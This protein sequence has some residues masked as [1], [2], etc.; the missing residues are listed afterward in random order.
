MDA[1]DA[2]INLAGS[3]QRIREIGHC[4]ASCRSKFV[5]NVTLIDTVGVKDS[6]GESEKIMRT[7]KET[8]PRHWRVECLSFALEVS[9]LTAGVRLGNVRG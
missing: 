7:K 5:D 4:I 8:L 3:P 1:V 2:W 6:E 9:L